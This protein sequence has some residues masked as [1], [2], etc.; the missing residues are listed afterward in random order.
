MKSILI[1]NF[2][3]SS[4]EHVGALRTQRLSTFSPV[5]LEALVITNL[6]NGKQEE[7]MK[8]S[9]STFYAPSLP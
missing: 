5:R 8:V 3:H 1:I 2:L 6:F 9:E 7:P 4:Q